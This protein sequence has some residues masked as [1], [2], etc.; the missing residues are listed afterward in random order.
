[1]KMLDAM[2]LLYN[3]IEEIHVPV[4]RYKNVLFTALLS[5]TNT[6]FKQMI[7][8]QKDNWGIGVRNVDSELIKK[9][10]LAKFMNTP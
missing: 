7:Q 3:E 5:G 8:F 10:V 2:D 9:V 4:A 1:M 6:K